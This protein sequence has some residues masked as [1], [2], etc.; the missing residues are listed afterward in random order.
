M[1]S[2]L[3]IIRRMYGASSGLIGARVKPQ[4]PPMTVVTPWTLDGEADG[5]QK[6][7]AS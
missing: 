6:S 7:W 5:S 2:T 3:A 4:F 1:P